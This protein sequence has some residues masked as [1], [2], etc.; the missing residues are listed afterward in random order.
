MNA[1]FIVAL[2]KVGFPHNHAVMLD[3]LLHQSKWPVKAS[4]IERGSDLRQPVANSVIRHFVER[5]WLEK[6]KSEKNGKKGK[7]AYLYR[8]KIDRKDL[9]ASIE[10]SI[11]DRM[12]QLRK[13]I[14]DDMKKTIMEA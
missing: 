2:K 12:I 5:G 3:Y 6:T 9:Q 8:L 11:I 1:E 13:L 4:E 7:P 10:E 14:N